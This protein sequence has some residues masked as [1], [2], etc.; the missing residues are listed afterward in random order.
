M[1]RNALGLRLTNAFLAEA[2]SFREEIGTAA[3]KSSIQIAVQEGRRWRNVTD[4]FDGQIVFNGNLAAQATTDFGDYKLV[5]SYSTE[6]HMMEMG[7]IFSRAELQT[8][9]RFEEINNVL[10]PGDFRIYSVSQLIIEERLANAFDWLKRLFHEAQPGIE[11]MSADTV[12]LKELAKNRLHD[13]TIVEQR[14]ETIISATDAAYNLISRKNYGRALRAL[15]KT[16][17]ETTVFE[18]RLTKF[19][20]AK[21]SEAE[22]SPYEVIPPE[23]DGYVQLGKKNRWVMVDSAS[24]LLTMP[25]AIAL[26]SLPFLGTYYVYYL[27]FLDGLH[28]VKSDPWFYATFGVFAGI[29]LIFPL[30]KVFLRLFLKRDYEVYKQHKAAHAGILEKRIFIALGIVVFIG[31]AI[32]FP[33]ALCNNVVFNQDGMIDNTEFFTY[34]GEFVPYEEIECV[35][36]VNAFLNGFGEVMENPSYAIRLNDGRIIDLRPIG[37]PDA[38]TILF[39][40]DKGIPMA[41]VGFIEDID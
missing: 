23:I 28:V 22:P 1:D 39:L 26:A 17:G 11:N 32:V 24:A 6:N 30:R 13:Q 34:T 21:I 31:I 25:F 40:L 29:F 9:Y 7:A 12:K 5:M 4:V 18:T 20:E 14:K 36:H 2:R 33:L 8:V 15:Q 10:S 41:T 38:G 27:V 16:Q 3:D 19:L 37:M 35:Y